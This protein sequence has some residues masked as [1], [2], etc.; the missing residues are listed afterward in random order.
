MRLRA[1]LFTPPGRLP[2]LDAVLRQFGWDPIVTAVES[3][4]LETVAS[5]TA[6]LIVIGPGGAFNTEGIALIRSVRMRD[7]WCP[8]LLFTASSSEAFAIE[9]LR[10]GATDLLLESASTGEIAEAVARISERVVDDIPEAEPLQGRERLVG[11]SVPARQV[12]DAIRRAAGVDSNVLIT[13]ETGTGKELVAQLIHANS[14]RRK[15]PLVSINCAAI[16]DTLLESELFGY[17]RGAFTGAVTSTPGKLEQASGG[18]IFF[19]EIGDMSLYAQAKIL[20]AIESREV[21]RLGG[22]RPVRVDV[23]VVAATHRDL[24]ELA[25]T[26]TFRKDLYFRINVARVHVAPLRER[27]HDIPLLVEHYIREYNRTFHTHVRDVDGE[28]L[29][30]LIAYEWPGNV[31]ELRN[32]IE[33]AFSSRP[34]GRITWIDLPE[35]LHRRLGEPALATGEPERIVSAL[36]STNWNKSKAAAK[37]QWSRM[38]LYRKMAKYQIDVSQP[39]DGGDSGCDTAGESAL[40]LSR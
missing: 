17:E 3:A 28:T 40:S 35:W 37:L 39:R 31:R 14:P 2:A 4:V 1:V 33:S 9:A 12:R 13:G 22:R 10:A 18:T 24:D 6:G 11:T 27:R 32:V 30:R 15:Q 7:P 34:A 8:V 25:M 29:D 26:D 36:A 16:P 5:R 23:R 20:R 21:C 38:T 19:D